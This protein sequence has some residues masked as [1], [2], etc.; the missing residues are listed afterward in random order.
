[1]EGL[2]ISDMLVRSFE[3]Y[4]IHHTNVRLPASSMILRRHYYSSNTQSDLSILPLLPSYL[5][6]FL[7]SSQLSTSGIY[8]A[9][10]PHP[11]TSKYVCLARASHIRLLPTRCLHATMMNFSSASII[12]AN[13]HG[14]GDGQ[15]VGNSAMSD[16]SMV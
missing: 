11:W 6:S 1:M 14:N 12:Q 4:T 9:H 2:Q 16:K 15:G 5:P 8:L 10:E 13:V 7:S 3:K